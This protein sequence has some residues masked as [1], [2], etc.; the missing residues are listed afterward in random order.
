MP[1]LKI[2]FPKGRFGMWQAEAIS[3]D[4]IPDLSRRGE[5]LTEGFKSRSRCSYEA[6]DERPLML[7]RQWTSNGGK[8]W[9]EPSSASCSNVA[10]RNSAAAF[11][12]ARMSSAG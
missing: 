8:V 7:I 4:T 3:L 2:A 1:L 9:R 12:T 10:F 6:M 5:V 11:A